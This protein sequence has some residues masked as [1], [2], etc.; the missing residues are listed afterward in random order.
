MVLIGMLYAPFHD[1]TGKT[2]LLSRG[3]KASFALGGVFLLLV[4][5][6]YALNPDWMWMYY[7][8]PDEVSWPAICYILIGLYVIPLLCG[9]YLGHELY[10]NGRWSWIAGMAATLLLELALLF[11]LWDRYN[12]IGTYVDFPA[13]RGEPL[14]GSTGTLALVMNI[15]GASAVVMGVYLWRRLKKKG[16]A[17]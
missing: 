10:L 3:A 16:D 12:F 8:D 5:V 17:R 1:R 7:I 4:A 14:V 11:L 15:G 2:V 6:S 9:I 13:R